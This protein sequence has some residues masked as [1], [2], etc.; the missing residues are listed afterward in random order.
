MLNPEQMAA[1]LAAGTSEAPADGSTVFLFQADGLLQATIRG[2]YA[3][4]ALGKRTLA[5]DE[6]YLPEEW[7]EGKPMDALKVVV[8]GVRT[9]TKHGAWRV[10]DA[11]GKRARCAECKDGRTDARKAKRAEAKTAKVAAALDILTAAPAEETV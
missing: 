9:C 11:E 7:A 6:V 10:W 5:E 8:T 4:S 2:E 3:V 1:L